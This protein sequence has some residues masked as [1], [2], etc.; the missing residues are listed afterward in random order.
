VKTTE[1]EFMLRVRQRLQQCHFAV[2]KWLLMPDIQSTGMHIQPIQV[3]TY[4]QYRYAHTTN[5]N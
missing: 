4:N 2:D 5:V 1:R 3:C